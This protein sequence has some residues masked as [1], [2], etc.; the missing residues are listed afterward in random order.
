MKIMNASVSRM[1]A[2]GFAKFSRPLAQS[3]LAFPLL[4]K[5]FKRPIRQSNKE[6]RSGKIAGPGWVNS[7]IGS[8][9]ERKKKQIPT[10]RKNNPP[11]WWL[12]M[13]AYNL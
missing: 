7:P 11:A 2:R 13:V 9:I 1:M 3:I 10:K 8:L 6:R 5:K 4:E 12:F